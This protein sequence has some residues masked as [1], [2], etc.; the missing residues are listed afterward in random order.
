MSGGAPDAMAPEREA[1]RPTRVADAIALGP[2]S[3]L[4]TWVFDLLRSASAFAPEPIEVR[5]I[6]RDHAVEPG[7]DRPRCLYLSHFPSPS[8]R[9]EWGRNASP[10]L[11]CLDDP[12]DSVRF[13]QQS[14]GGAVFEALRAQTVAAASYGELRGHPRV[15]ILHRLAG[16]RAAEIIDTIVV[17]LGLGLDM[18]QRAALRPKHLPEGQPDAA[19]EAA[20][21]AHVPGYAPLGENGL[22]P[23][24]VTTIGG[25]LS[26]LLQL[27]FRD[28]PG[29]IVWPVEAFFSGDKP[30][31]PAPPVAELTGGA[32]ILYYGPYFYL[33]SGGWKVRLTVGFSAEARSLPFSV[34]VYAGERM[35]AIATMRGEHGVYHAT[36]GFVHDDPLQAVEVRIR[37]DR[38]AIEGRLALGNVEFTR[39]TATMAS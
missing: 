27:S 1:A 17:H 33:P 4:A 2:P 7:G 26:P 39:E 8:L 29:P 10:I 12:V 32:R 6:D 38:G 28:V 24:E 9:A 19:L 3:V 13:V 30:N 34:E 21:Q 23:K 22:A 36:F 16:A 11:L 18:A 5:V 35:L 15:L 37:T 20:L 14:S 25:V 31:T